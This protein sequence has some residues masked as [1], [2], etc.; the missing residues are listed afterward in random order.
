MPLIQENTNLEQ[1]VSDI[2]QADEETLSAMHM[3]ITLAGGASCTA[4]LASSPDDN[5][6]GIITFKADGPL[7][8]VV[9]T[10]EVKC[11]TPEEEQEASDLADALKEA[12]GIN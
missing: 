4:Q 5:I 3:V 1:A 9:L 11:G 8:S 10:M 7:A 12:Y 2:L 6:A